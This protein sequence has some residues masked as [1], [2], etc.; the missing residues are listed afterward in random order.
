MTEEFS[1]KPKWDLDKQDELDATKPCSQGYDKKE[2]YMK[3]T[4][5]LLY[6]DIGHQFLEEV[7]TILPT[8]A[9]RIRDSSFDHI[10]P[11]T[12][13]NIAAAAVALSKNVVKFSRLSNERDQRLS[14]MYRKY[15]ITSDEQIKIPSN[16]FNQ[17]LDDLDFTF[18]FAPAVA[19]D[20]VDAFL[21]AG[22][23]TQEEYDQLTLGDIANMVGSGW[24][25]DLMH[26]MALTRNGVYGGYG[27]EASHYQ[28]GRLETLLEETCDV[29]RTQRLFSISEQSDDDGFTYVT[30]ALARPVRRKLRGE[31]SLRSM[32]GQTEDSVGCPVA[33]RAGSVAVELAQG[34]RAQS[35]VDRSYMHI[36]E[37]TESGNVR[38]HQDYTA[39][40]HALDVTAT[41]LDRYDS[42]YGTP[43]TGGNPWLSGAVLHEKRQKVDC[44]RYRDVRSN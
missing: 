24:F 5:Y 16:A 2:K 43:V 18:H 41:L 38:L 10:I 30:A 8:K 39:I 37:P 23:I 34:K 11:P 31:M 15:H 19:V 27:K 26:D 4:G 21:D 1:I 17:G 25:S 35:L 6:S 9:T 32:G 13:L 20:V 42:L 29:P 14:R 40:D 3:R 44:F 33:R 7:E 12:Q 28:S 36:G 22:I